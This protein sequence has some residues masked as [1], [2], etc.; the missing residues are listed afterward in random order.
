MRSVRAFSL[1]ELLVVVVIVGLWA[2]IA[3]PRLADSI[4]HHRVEAAAGRVA[5]DL[6]LAR[7]QARTTSGNVTVRFNVSANTYE[8][9]P[10]QPVR[11]PAR[12]YEVDLGQE[13][14]QVVLVYAFSKS[15]LMPE[16]VFNGFGLP[17]GGG[18]IILRAGQHEQTVTLDAATGRVGRS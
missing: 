6:Q 2:S 8:V 16:V 10:A 3:I 4:A 13:P 9:I 12:P 14:Y 17:N 5:R 15:E 1:I 11:L 18:K 7:K